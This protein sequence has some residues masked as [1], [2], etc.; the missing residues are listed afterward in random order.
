M[1]LPYPRWRRDGING[2][3]GK[4]LSQTKVD[5]WK[6][7]VE[8]PFHV[9]DD[10]TIDELR[11]RFFGDSSNELLPLPKTPS[12]LSSESSDDDGEECMMAGIN[13]SG[14]GVR[15]THD[16]WCFRPGDSFWWCLCLH[17]AFF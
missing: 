14:A 7:H 1:P 15:V 9:H 2:W 6:H 3:F 16:D 17:L 10:M 11:W 8:V 13:E 4:A 5:E 12:S